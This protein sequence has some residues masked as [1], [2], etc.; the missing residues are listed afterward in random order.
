MLL[1]RSTEL[2]SA[3]K[4]RLMIRRTDEWVRRCTRTTGPHNEQGA[5]MSELSTYPLET[6][7]DDGEFVLSRRVADP[8]I[9]SAPG[10]GPRLGTAGVGKRRAARARLFAPGDLDSAWAARPVALEY[11]EGRPMLLIED[12]GGKVLA[13]FSASRGT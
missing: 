7:W 11:H 2:V 4:Q 9:L 1:A 13:R 8:E 3:F 6:L 12:P 10:A 5:S